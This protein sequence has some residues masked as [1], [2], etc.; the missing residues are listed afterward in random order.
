MHAAA[1]AADTP[2]P[3]LPAFVCQRFCTVCSKS[4]KMT[5]PVSLLKI[6]YL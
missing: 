3:R 5:G 6:I 2:L 4:S 1:A